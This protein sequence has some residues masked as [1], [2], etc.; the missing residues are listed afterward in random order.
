MMMV[1]TFGPMGVGFRRAGRHKRLP[2][3][4]NVAGLL[5]FRQVRRDLRVVRFDIA[6]QPA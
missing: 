4:D 5:L 2:R 3:Q 1:L 6:D